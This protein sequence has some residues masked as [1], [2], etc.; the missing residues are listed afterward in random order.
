MR[1][2]DE[3]FSFTVATPSG[4][5][6]KTPIIITNNSE[7]DGGM[8]EYE[9]MLWTE[10]ECTFVSV[11]LFTCSILGTVFNLLVASVYIQKS[12]KCTYEIFVL[13][14]AFI[15]LGGCSGLVVIEYWFIFS[16]FETCNQPPDFTTQ[17]RFYHF[18]DDW[19]LVLLVKIFQI[20]SI[21]DFLA[22]HRQD[23]L[24]RYL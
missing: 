17:V 20:L 10:F 23:I 18:A 16:S 15:N 11:F 21:L 2:E 12:P 14:L 9:N 8:G 7:R 24:P 19:T 6:N 1:T 3:N 5:L 13:F 4:D 22:K